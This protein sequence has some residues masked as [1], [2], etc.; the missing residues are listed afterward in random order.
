MIRLANM[1][2]GLVYAHDDI[3]YF[4]SQYG[5]KCHLGYFRIDSMPYSAIK[6]LLTGDSITIIDATRKRK[7]YT[8][9]QKFGVPTWCLVFNRAI[10]YRDLKVCEWQTPEMR[11]VAMSDFHSP[12]IQSIRK[13]QKIYGCQEPA[14][15]GKNII[16]ECHQDAVFDDKP[17]LLRELAVA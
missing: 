9:A 3:C 12:M 4:Q 2:N 14:I 1:C 6:A 10:G 5:H 17:A 16:I 11:G 13:L 7:L 15:I 8:D